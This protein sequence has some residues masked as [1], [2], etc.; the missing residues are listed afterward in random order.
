M[1]RVS[2]WSKFSSSKSTFCIIFWK[3]KNSKTWHTEHYFL[4]VEI[5]NR[6][7][8]I[9]RNIFDKPINNDIKP[10]ENIIRLLLVK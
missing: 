2:D 5:K 7:V 1:L 8:K 3:R 9:D 4:K 6:N 10:Y